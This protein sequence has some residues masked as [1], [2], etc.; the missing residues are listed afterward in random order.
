MKEVFTHIQEFLQDTDKGIDLY[1]RLPVCN[2]STLA[3]FR[4]GEDLRRL[5]A[6]RFWRDLVEVMDFRSRQGKDMRILPAVLEQVALPTPTPKILP[7]QEEKVQ[8][9]LPTDL[10]TDYEGL[11]K[12]KAILRNLIGKSNDA[13]ALLGTAND[14]ET[15][16]KRLALVQ[17]ITKAGEQIT[18]VEERILEI[19][20]KISRVVNTDLDA[21]Y[22]TKRNIDANVTKCKKRIE[23]LGKRLGNEPKNEKLGTEISKLKVKYHH[24]K[25]EQTEAGIR[26]DAAKQDRL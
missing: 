13:L 25:Q 1:S 12:E 3:K 11:F 22:Q 15:V 7:A 16:A 10:P 26:V 2:A 5:R 4:K 6:E 19:E 21:L 18:E 17:T 9:T 23:E 14:A 20:G 8:E 24:L